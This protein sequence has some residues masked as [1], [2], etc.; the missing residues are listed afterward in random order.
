V[1]V[2]YITY[3]GLLDPL[4]SSQ[5]LPY[6]KGISKHQDK[7]VIMSFEKPERLLHGKDALLS[8]LRNYSITWEPLLFTKGLGFL[9]KLMDLSCMYLK[10]FIIT[11]KYNIKVVHTRGHPSAQVGLFVKR[12]T[13]AKLIFDFRGLWVDERVDKGGWD[14]NRFFH[15][16]QYKYYKRVERKLLIQSDHIVVLTNKVV[17]EVIKL[18]AIEQSRITVIPCCADYN[19]F[20]L[21]TESHKIEARAS[22]GI[23]NDAFVLGYLGSIGKMYLLDRFFHLFKLA[24]NVRKDC[25]ALLITRDTASLKQ[26]MKSHLTPELSS[27]VHIKS[28]SRDEVP[29]LLPAIDVMISFILS[30]YARTGASPTKIAEC[31]ALGIPVIAN[32]GVGDVKQVVDR[33]DGGWIVDPCSDTDLMEVVQNLDTIC[34]KGGR[35]L[36]DASRSMLGLEFATQC[37]QSIYDKLA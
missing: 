25:Y 22:L 7:V 13:K 4:G 11:C 9:G 21:S 36:R 32:S 5:I 34:S 8:D 31:F 28:A 2:L 37:Y 27:R 33:L 10:A 23:P 16:L 29:V 35:R 3:D 1:I 26:L 24:V 20:P 12:I 15:R 19:H 30:T 14:L 18:G 17:D 6:V